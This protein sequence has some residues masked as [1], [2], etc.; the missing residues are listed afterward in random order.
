ME[1]QLHD[2]ADGTPAPPLERESLPR[3]KELYTGGELLP[4]NVFVEALEMKETES[5]NGHSIRFDEQIVRLRDKMV[6]SYKPVLSAA[7][8]PDKQ[9]PEKELL[10][11]CLFWFYLGGGMAT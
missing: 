9:I 4:P 8:I 3:F 10:D 11:F 6:L 2:L 1:Q 5:V 7:R